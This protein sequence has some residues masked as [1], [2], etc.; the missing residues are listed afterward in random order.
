MNFF[1]L[2]LGLNFWYTAA[3]SLS[4]VWEISGAVSLRFNQF[5]FR[6]PSD[7][8]I[9]PE[10]DLTIPLPPGVHNAL[11]YKSQHSRQCTFTLLMIQQIFKF[12][13]SVSQ[14]GGICIHVYRLD[15][16]GEDMGQSLELPTHV[17]PSGVRYIDWFRNTFVEQDSK[18]T[19]VEN[20]GQ[21]S[22]FLSL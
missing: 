8:L 17:G 14:G 13:Q 22:D 9:W 19:E 10:V 3:G 16:S 6:A 12:R 20:R 5:Q 15:Y 21:I 7:I 11:G 18:A 2:C 4:A 1:V